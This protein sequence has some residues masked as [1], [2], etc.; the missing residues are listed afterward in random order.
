MS[1]II[2]AQLTPPWVLNRMIFIH[3]Y[4]SQIYSTE[5]FTIAQLVSKIPYSVLCAVLYWVLMVYPIGFGQGASGL[6]GTGFQLLVLIFV[7]FFSVT[8]T[9]L[10]SAISPSIQIAVLC[11]LLLATILMT[12]CSVVIL[13]PNIREWA[14]MWLYC[15]DPFTHV[16]G[17][18]ISAELHR[19]KIECKSN[20]FS[21]FKPPEGQA[22]SAWV[23]E[24][25]SA[26]G[27]YLDNTNDTSACQYCPYS[28]GED[29]F[30]LLKI[31]YKDRWRDVFM[32]FGFFIFNM[33][34][35]RL[36][37]KSSCLLALIGVA[38][39]SISCTYVFGFP[40]SSQCIDTLY[41][42]LLLD[43]HGLRDRVC[44]NLI[45]CCGTHHCC[46]F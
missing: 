22:C 28:V 39:V 19:L 41:S 37:L 35:S 24:F 3:K 9:Q 10:V 38:P 20:K 27:V 15:L 14:R 32:L 25:V 34:T 23:N 13:Y 26:F 11:N 6:H 5:A 7:K 21:V 45:I 40:T 29:F 46:L 42:P 44:T 33:I 1:A 2:K 36:Y 4:H 12:F 43:E 18:M 30:I 8:L 31:R 17:A 16:M